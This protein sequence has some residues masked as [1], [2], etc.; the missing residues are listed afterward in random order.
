MMHAQKAI[1]ANGTLTMM[2][3]SQAITTLT[4]REGTICSLKDFLM[5]S[6]LSRAEMLFLNHEPLLVEIK[7]LR[8]NPQQKTVICEMIPLQAS[9]PTNQQLDE[10]TLIIDSN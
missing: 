9:I 3:V 10:I 7:N 1:Y 2:N 4:N 8:Y 6:D 5:T